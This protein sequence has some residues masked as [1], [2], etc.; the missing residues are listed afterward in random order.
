M[1]II[2]YLVILILSLHIPALAQAQAAASAPMPQGEGV[3]LDIPVNP[4]TGTIILFPEPVISVSSSEFYKIEAVRGNKDPATGTVSDVAEFIVRPLSPNSATDDVTFVLY[5]LRSYNI[6]F[7]PSKMA[8]K[9]Y[10]I[11]AVFPSMQQSGSNSQGLRYDTVNFLSTETKLMKS[12]LMDSAGNF[13]RSVVNRKINFAPY[14]EGLGVNLVRVFQGPN[15]TGYTF[16]FRN[17]SSSTIQIAPQNLSM[18]VP[19]MA[20]MVQSDRYI[21]PPCSL[22]RTKC[23]TAVRYIVGQ[24]ASETQGINFQV[25]D[26]SMPFVLTNAQR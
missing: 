21:L 10:R 6:R 4:D 19:N 16:I 3:T 2:Y 8:D 13:S 11:K 20:V 15:V 22:N 17:I 24:K 23:K 9:Y 1:N 18:G 12:M 14:T 7:T 25:T 5:S 26:A